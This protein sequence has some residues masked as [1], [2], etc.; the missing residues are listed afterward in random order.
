MIM[1]GTLH[2]SYIYGTYHTHDVLRTH[3]ADHKLI[4]LYLKDIMY[5]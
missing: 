2:T 4:K 3:D 1:Y 5:L